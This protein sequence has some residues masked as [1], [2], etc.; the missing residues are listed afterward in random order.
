MMRLRA[1]IRGAAVLSLQWSRSHSLRFRSRTRLRA[2]IR[3]AA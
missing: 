2:L 1:L 3:G